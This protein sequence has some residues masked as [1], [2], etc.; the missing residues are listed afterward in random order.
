MLQIIMHEMQKLQHFGF[1]NSMSTGHNTA[2]KQKAY[3][4]E[5]KLSFVF[6]SPFTDYFIQVFE[7]LPFYLV[8]LIHA[9]FAF[10]YQ[11]YL[12]S[13]NIVHRD[14]ACRNILIGRNKLLK[15]SDFGMSR[16]VMEDEVYINT[17]H[18]RLPLR[19][20][21]VESIFQREFTIASDV[22]AYGIV[23]WEIATM[24]EYK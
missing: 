13:L 11:E 21:A 3:R 18:G 22:W 24:G 14:L 4:L 19:W 15:I 12:S 16:V 9:Q 7:T 6:V 20:M 23:L 5:R 8:R 2:K 1:S 10:S 17:S